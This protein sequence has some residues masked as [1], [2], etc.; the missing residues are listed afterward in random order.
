MSHFRSA[1]LWLRTVVDWWL[2]TD[3]TTLTLLTGLRSLTI[4]SNI[5]VCVSSDKS[6]NTEMLDKTILAD[7]TYWDT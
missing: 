6:E 4:S 2:M 7:L 5:S 1:F 3:V